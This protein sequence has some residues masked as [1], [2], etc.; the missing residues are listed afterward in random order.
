MTRWPACRRDWSIQDSI[1]AMGI[2]VDSW[3]I[4]PVQFGVAG[5]HHDVDGVEVGLKDAVHV[6][7][8]VLWFYISMQ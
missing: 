8:L 1:R 4:T 3:P 2:Q 6:C 5:V 7:H